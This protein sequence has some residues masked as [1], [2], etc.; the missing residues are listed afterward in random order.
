M[1]KAGISGTLAAAV[2]PLRDRG[3]RLDEAAFESLYGFYRSSDLNGVLVL[4][5]TG[6][7]ILLSPGERRRVAERAI[8]HAGH[9]RVIV[10]C[11]A[12]SSAETSALARHAAEAGAAG[13]AVIA[14]PYFSFT[15]P[16][17]LEH[18][19]AAAAACAPLPFY[20]Y[21][22]AARSGYTVPVAVVAS[23]RERAPN[24]V[25]MKVSDAPFDQV[26]P[27]LQTGLDVFIGAE[28]LIPAG[29]AGGA[30]GAVSGVAA[31]FPEAVC[32]LVCD[33]TPERLE[34]VTG[35]RDKLS[36]APFQASVKA[37]LGLRG[38]SI[39]GDV[40]APLLPLRDEELMRLRAELAPLL[41]REGAPA[42]AGEAA[43]RAP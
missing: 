39:R 10:H 34:L 42:A 41:Q 22:Y 21:E 2:T 11:G 37:A 30:V 35:L 32:A 38:V 29:L 6:E 4:G 27:Y 40:R 15:A 33:P 16:E 9:L 14:P 12:Q 18:F 7:G 28:A 1:D 26:E 13:V 43:H 19:A 36:L 8:A 23:L 3:E 20:V 31:A 17:L 24:L 5:T 25:G